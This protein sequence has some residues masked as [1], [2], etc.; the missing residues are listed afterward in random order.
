MDV[1]MDKMIF[2]I[3]GIILLALS[4]GIVNTMLMVILERTRELGMLMSV[5][6]NKM[7][8]FLLVLFET[9]MLSAIGGPIGMVLSSLMIGYLQETGIDLSS[10]GEGLKTFG[11]GSTIYPKLLEGDLLRIG[12]MVVAIGILSAIYPAIKALKLNPAEAVRAV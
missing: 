11:I 4:F 8:I 12:L 6:M 2:I 5:G 10:V 9:V 7:K 3:M 1:M